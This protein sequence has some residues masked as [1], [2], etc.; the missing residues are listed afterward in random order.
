MYDQNITIKIKSLI[1]ETLTIDESL[2]TDDIGPGDLTEWDSLAHQSVISRIEEEF[3]IAF[4]ADEMLD[5]E[6]LFDIV[7]TL[8]VRLSN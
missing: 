6:S 2:L 7:E 5:M 8:K 3:S 4:T 1:S